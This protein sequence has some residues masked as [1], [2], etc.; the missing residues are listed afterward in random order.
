MLF[1]SRPAEQR[2]Q[3]LIAQQRAAPFSYPDVGA[4]RGEFLAGY[5]VL[6]C[7]VGLGLGPAVYASAQQ[8]LGNWK[9][10]T[11]PNISLHWPAP[12]APG[13]VVAVG[14]RHVGFWSLNFYRIVYAINEDTPVARYGFA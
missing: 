8:A 10:F 11:I 12:S 14:V 1:L 3:T 5:S 6:R 4:T 2:V 13:T 7:R 9:M